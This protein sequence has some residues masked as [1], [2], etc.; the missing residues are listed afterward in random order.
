MVLRCHRC[1][2]SPR[3][4]SRKRRADSSIRPSVAGVLRR[5]RMLVQARQLQRTATPGLL[6][7]TH[8]VQRAPLPALSSLL[9][10]LATGRT[11][12]KQNSH[13]QPQMLSRSTHERPTTSLVLVTTF[14]MS[15]RQNH[16]L[17]HL[18]QRGT[19]PN[20]ARI[21]L[22]RLSPNSRVSPSRLQSAKVRTDI[23][24]CLPLHLLWIHV[25]C[26]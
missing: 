26:P 24:A 15:P 7:Q 11:H 2:T 3:S 16:E 4:Q 6:L 23:M 19:Q 5:T 14:S 1:L 22:H 9:S 25:A 13:H 12:G 18:Q 20:P 21:Q 17:R 8:G 10:A